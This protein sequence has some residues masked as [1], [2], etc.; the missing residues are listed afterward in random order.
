MEE[1]ITE[2]YLDS[3]VTPPGWLLQSAL[4]LY[5]SGYHWLGILRGRGSDGPALQGETIAGR[6]REL[7]AAHYDMP[8]PLFERML[9]PSLK[10]STGLWET[11]AESLEAAQEAMLADA[12]RKAGL[13]DGDAVLDVGCGF[14]P[15]CA[16]AWSRGITTV[17]SWST[18]EAVI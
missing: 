15:S 17:R 1:R 7:M 10:Y 12:C 13:R 18:I 14:G 3:R 2:H 11:G 6:S 4:D 5:L 8:L 9:G 16:S